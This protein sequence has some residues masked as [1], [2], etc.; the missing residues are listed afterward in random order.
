MFAVFL[1]QLRAIVGP[2]QVAEV[3]EQ[4]D[5]SESL[6]RRPVS[7]NGEGDCQEQLGRGRAHDLESP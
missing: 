7:G 4:L 3:F 1:A 5:D 2:D 6:L